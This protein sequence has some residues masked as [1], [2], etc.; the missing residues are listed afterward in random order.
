[1]PNALLKMAVLFFLLSVHPLVNGVR[2]SAQ[3]LPITADS[4]QLQS[5]IPFALSSGFER[6]INTFLWDFTATSTVQTGRWKLAFNDRFQR[7]LIKT[8][9][10]SI[11][12]QN[13]MLI[14]ASYALVDNMELRS[15]L[16]S[17][18]FT[19]D[20]G[21]GLN[22]LT[23]TKALGGFSWTL[24]DHVQLTPLAGYSI[25]NQQG[26]RDEGF[27]YT[28]QLLLNGLRIGQT[29]ARG[30]LFLSAEHISPRYQYEHRGGAELSARIGDNSLNIAQVT[31]RETRR[32]FYQTPDEMHLGTIPSQL[33]ESRREQTIGV[34][35][36]LRYSIVRSLSLLATM[37]LSQRNITRDRNEHQKESEAPFFSTSISEFTLNGS[38]QIEYDNFS[39]TRGSLRLE[40]N[41]RDESH[42]LE[43]FDGAAPTIVARQQRLEEQKNNVIQQAQIGLNFSHAIGR[44]DTLAFSGATVKLQYDTPSEENFDD[45]D[46]L[47]ILTG[48]RWARRFGP[49]FIAT[50]NGDLA[51][52]HTVYIFAERSA[53]NTWNRVLR[54]SP[55][56]ELRVA[57][58]FVSKNSAEIVANYT[59]Y[60]FEQTEQGQRSFSL[61]QLTLIDSTAIRITGKYWFDTAFHFRWYERGELRWSAF[62]VR[63]VQ[64]FQ[65][66]TVSLALQRRGERWEISAG[67]R[68]FEQ[69]RY[70]YKG[71]TRNFVG[72]L[73]NYG[74]T[75]QLRFALSPQSRI[76]LDGWY[77]LTSEADGATRSTPNI[78]LQSIWNL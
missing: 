2:L 49:G 52:R 63:P 46:E 34:R 61:R 73:R 27:A 60:D 51:M 8:G 66:Q 19:D 41:E 68:Y 23:T 74:P 48:V 26:I 16:T 37:D 76:L 50:L 25:D 22:D 69:N 31:Y 40:L 78:I 12:D 71:S 20:R 29:D 42:Q 33:I 36:V 57:Q 21:L 64:F 7:T 72:R 59:V 38:T 54:L 56:S 14:D 32:E 45:R 65:E 4:L 24:F 6:N 67:L 44:S 58:S 35:D 75:A 9:G 15:A 1:M 28:A 39:G 30:E 53:N 10:E 62:T 5:S 3:E 18:T 17:F 70:G 13:S 11:K 77:Q 47:V 43:P 55:A